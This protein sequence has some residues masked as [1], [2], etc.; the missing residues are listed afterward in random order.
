MLDLAGHATPA[1]PEI[2]GAHALALPAHPPDLLAEQASLN[3]RLRTASGAAAALFDRTY[4]PFIARLADYLHTLPAMPGGPPNGL[5]ARALESGLLAIQISD[6]RILPGTGGITRREG[7]DTAWRFAAF[8]AAA[9]RALQV[10]ASLVAYAE[11]GEVWHPAAESLTAWRDRLALREAYLLWFATGDP[12]RAEN[13]RRLIASR[14]LDTAQ[15]QLLIYAG[16]NIAADLLSAI[17]AGDDGPHPGTVARIAVT[18]ADA[19]APE[20]RDTPSR[21]GIERFV[22][23]ALRR[24]ARA[25]A[26]TLLFRLTRCG[27][28]L[29]WPRAVA[30]LQALLVGEGIR[31]PR[32][33]D[34]LAELML[35]GG[36]IRAPAACPVRS[37]PYWAVIANG[38]RWDECVLVQGEW[39]RTER[40]PVILDAAIDPPPPGV[41]APPPPDP[42]PRPAAETGDGAP[43]PATPAQP[44]EADHEG[45]DLASAGMPGQLLISVCGDL[46][47]GRR[48]LGRDVIELPADQIAIRFP[49][50]LRGYDVDPIEGLQAMRAKDWLVPCPRRETSLLHE[51]RDRFGATVRAICLRP[52]CVRAVRGLIHHPPA[53]TELPP[54]NALSPDAL[55]R[56]LCDAVSQGTLA[57]RSA[58]RSQRDGIELPYPEV[59]Q[60]LAERS[61]ASFSDVS[62]PILRGPYLIRNGGR[63][64]QAA[65]DRRFVVLKCEF[66][67]GLCVSLGK[68]SAATAVPTARAEKGG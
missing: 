52:A 36:F 50:A 59:F 63:P 61:G 56:A 29:H 20:G 41:D 28:F 9:T 34:S 48:Q 17:A 2:G 47:S 55:L 19:T 45:V 46:A 67:G 53:R 21:R 11:S 1:P 44:E 12:V 16:E 64:I 14:L 25:P 31:V 23:D 13:L 3:A 62:M 26:G 24:L 38:E 10:L 58:V 6:G 18:A 66:A 57:W 65:G 42:P 51:V 37:R 43:P 40:M 32:D 7:V 49:E 15:W 22:L 30:Q 4:A 39:L 33:P 60:F 54:T 68:S 27:L 35:E 5:L 8:A